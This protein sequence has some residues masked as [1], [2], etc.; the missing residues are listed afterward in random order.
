MP[1]RCPTG[2]R[3]PVGG[4]RRSGPGSARPWREAVSRSH[5]PFEERQRQVAFCFPGQGEP[6]DAAAFSAV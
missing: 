5:R 1:A 4:A 3:A 6:A 2:F